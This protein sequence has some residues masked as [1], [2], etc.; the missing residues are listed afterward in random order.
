MRTAVLTLLGSMVLSAAA[1]PANA[2]PTAARPGAPTVS[3][4]VQVSGCGWGFY[5]DMYGYCQPYSY[6]A[7]YGSPAWYGNPYPHWFYRDHNRHR[8]HYQ[9]Q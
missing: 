7:W 3:K 9:G 1:I 4:V 2:G 8:D 6:A 5:R